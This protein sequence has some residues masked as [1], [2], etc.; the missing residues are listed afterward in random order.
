M[1]REARMAMDDGGRPARNGRV[2]RAFFFGLIALSCAIGELVQSGVIK[3]SAEL[4]AVLR[5]MFMVLLFVGASA[6][7][8]YLVRTWRKMSAAVPGRWT[9]W[10]FFVGALGMLAPFFGFPVLFVL[11]RLD[12]ATVIPLVVAM[13]IGMVLIGISILAMVAEFGFKGPVTPQ[14]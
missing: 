1:S 2:R 12:D 13:V 6:A 3:L 11:Q 9:H 5:Y 4:I 10:I 14:K 8:V 7:L